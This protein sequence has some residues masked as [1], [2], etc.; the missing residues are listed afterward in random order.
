MIN[1]D[2]KLIGEINGD[3]FIPDY[4]RGYR[5][6]EEV[7][8]LLED[9][10]DIPNDKKYCLQPIVVKKVD[11]KFELI[12]GQQ[13]LT[14]IYLIQKYIKLYRPKVTI[15]YSIDYIIRKDSQKFLTELDFSN[16]NEDPSNIDEYFINEAAK[17]IKNWFEKEPTKADD[18]ASLIMDRFNRHISILW[19]EVDEKEDSAELFKRLN[20][21]KIPLTNAELIKALFLK[22]NNGIDN[23]KQLEIATQWDIIEKELHD[24]NFWYFLTN[25]KTEKYPTRIELLFDLIAQKDKKDKER[26]RTF[27]YFN[28]E[29]KTQKQKSDSW[30]KILQYYQ[31]LKE[32]YE[33]F[34]LYH[35]VGYLIAIDA[36]SLQDLIKSSNGKTKSDYRNLLVEFI[37]ESIKLKDKEYAD[38]MYGS[39]DKT[40]QRLLL[41]FNM[42]TIRKKGDEYMRFPF[43]RHKKESWSL[44][45]IH[46]QNSEGLNT[47]EARVQWLESHLKSIRSFEEIN[48]ERNKEEKQNFI[49]EIEALISKINDEKDK[50]NKEDRF[51]RIFDRIIKVL[52]ENGSDDYK[53]FLSNM[54]LLSHGNNAALSNSTFDVKRNKIIEM[55]K[56]TDYIPVCTRRVFFKYYTPS[57]ENQLHFWGKAD[58]DAY[59]KEMNETLKPYL[60]R[61]QQEIKA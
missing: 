25:E 60:K 45:H 3:F 33:D 15:N 12:D 6:N 51:N 27:F 43:S 37:A 29:M 59:I 49:Q 10:K 2:Q 23:P 54:A 56:S 20:I 9:I 61:N 7:T 34:D 52:S 30:T 46:A 31:R 24:D 4:Q 50:T 38:L 55:D 28:E 41:L 47:N 32:W 11:N 13:R 1:F 53:D 16:I 22:Q 21:G 44:E 14:T 26:Y 17:K 35:K 48:F 18:L 42:E 39:D 19:Y 8:M 57:A 40:I 5:W 36:K 58:R